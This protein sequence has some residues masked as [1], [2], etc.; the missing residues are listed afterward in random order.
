[1]AEPPDRIPVLPPDRIP[2]VPP[3]RIAVVVPARDEAGA[4]AACL[5]SIAVAA[6]LVTVPVEVIVVADACTDDTAEV[7][8]AMGAIVVAATAGNVG[9]ARG[10]G[11][12]HALRHGTDG[13]WLANTDADS[14]VPAHWLLGQLRLAADGAD[15]V[16]GTVRVDRWDDWPAHLPARY[17]RHYRDAQRLG[18][19][20]VHGAN[21][22]LSGFAYQKVGGFPAVAVGEDRALVADALAAGLCLAYPTDLPVTTSARPVARVVGGGFHQ[23]L[24]RLARTP[25][26][27]NPDAPR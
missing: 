11:C 5:R 16:A 9:T 19:H 18:V 23:F 27:V 10:L 7:A 21:L 17:R 3:D 25:A 12:A 4:V 2:V 22:G 15:V 20:H 14:T 1:M 24:H 26:P 6:R 8:G 13:L